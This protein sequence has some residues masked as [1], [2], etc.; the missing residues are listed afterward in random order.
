MIA[1]LRMRRTIYT[2]MNLEHKK[3]VFNVFNFK[4]YVDIRLRCNYLLH[5]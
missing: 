3:S 1:E 4:K 5:L 2:I